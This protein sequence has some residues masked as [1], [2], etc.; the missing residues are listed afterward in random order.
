MADVLSVVMRWLHLASVATLIGGLLYARL[1]MV[2]AA[3]LM[4]TEV[5]EN[6]ADKAA[7]RFRPLALAAVAALIVSGVYN[8]VSSPG[9]SPR[10][11]ILLGIKLLLALH[12]F[13]VGWLVVQPR[14]SRRARQMAGAVISGFIIIAISAYLRRI[15]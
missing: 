2:G 11:H 9:H 14:N 10:Y 15:F 1:V 12:V 7:E 13:A 8:I 6:L 4:G 3:S 5:R